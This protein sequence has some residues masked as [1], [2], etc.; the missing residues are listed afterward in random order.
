MQEITDI[1]AFLPLVKL[2]FIKDNEYAP[3]VKCHPSRMSPVM[4]HISV[5]RGM[6]LCL[7]ST[8]S[9][10]SGRGPSD[11]TM[12]LKKTLRPVSFLRD[13][14]RCEQLGGKTPVRDMLSRMSGRTRLWTFKDKDLSFMGPYVTSRRTRDLL[15]RRRDRRLELLH[16]LIPPRDLDFRVV[17]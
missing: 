16:L 8:V 11:L 1:L 17:L 13:A 7:H 12:C 10:Q 3:V 4:A 9:P 6:Y 5:S 2:A 15:T 14:P